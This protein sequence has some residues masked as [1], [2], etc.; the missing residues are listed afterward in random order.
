MK[1]INCV[2]F[3]VTAWL[4]M[5]ISMLVMTAGLI[6]ILRVSPMYSTAFEMW[7]SIIVVSLVSATIATKLPE[8]IMEF[9]RRD[10]ER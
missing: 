8:R 10:D 1:F 2:R 4:S 3:V 5:A 6:F 9:I 7:L